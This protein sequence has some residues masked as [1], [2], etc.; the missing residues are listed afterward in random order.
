MFNLKII[1]LIVSS[2]TT[3]YELTI[4]TCDGNFIARRTINSTSVRFCLYTNACCIK[5]TAKYRNQTIVKSMLLQN[6]KCQTRGVNFN[7]VPIMPTQQPQTFILLDANYSFP[8]AYA[9]LNF[10]NT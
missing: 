2:S 9:E 8:I 5:F 4:S 3:P 7:F 6:C 10:K 1:N